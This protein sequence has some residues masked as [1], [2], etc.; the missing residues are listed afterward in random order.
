MQSIQALNRKQG[1]LIGSFVFIGLMTF[2]VSLLLPESYRNILMKENGVVETLSAVGYVLAVIAMLRLGGREYLTK[3]WY[4]AV[5]LL[6]FSARELDFDKRFT[7]F[8]VLKSKFFIHPD[9]S[10]WGKAIAGMILLFILYALI[11]MVRRH[12]RTF[13]R[14]VLTF[15]WSPMIWSIGL[16]GSFLVFSKSIDGLGRKLE[17]WGIAHLSA[18]GD[19]IAALA[20]ESMEFVVPYLFI[21]AVFNQVARYKIALRKGAMNSLDDV[22][23]ND[24]CQPLKP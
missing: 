9:V 3:Y 5:I 17:G 15:R 7:N 16:A 4:A 18:Q 24:T 12:G 10:W 14:D 20:E 13:I 8:G 11:T 1:W 21:I 22:C 19:L 23:F 2:A 6:S